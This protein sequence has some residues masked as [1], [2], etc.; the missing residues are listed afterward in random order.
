MHNDPSFS[1]CGSCRRVTGDL[2]GNRSVAV[3]TV[4]TFR[5]NSPPYTR[6]IYGDVDISIVASK[7]LD[8][9]TAH[10][11]I[12]KRHVDDDGLDGQWF[13]ADVQDLTTFDVVL[14]IDPFRVPPIQIRHGVTICAIIF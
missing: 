6:S 9:N 13:V 12:F 10:L 4:R 14:V 11:L 8:F 3:P 7:K 5:T 1:M 2:N